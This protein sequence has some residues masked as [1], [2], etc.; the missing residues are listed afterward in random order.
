MVP[1]GYKVKLLTVLSIFEQ[2][3]DKEHPLSAD[4]IAEL[5]TTKLRI[6]CSRKGIYDDINALND[7]WDAVNDSRCIERDE[8]GKGYYLANRSFSAGDVKLMVDAIESSKYLSEAKTMKLITSLQKLCPETQVSDMK[9]QLVVFDRVKNMNTEI[10]ESLGTISFAISHD[11]QIR[12]KY[13]DY[14]MNKRRAY[15]KKGEFYQMSPYELIYT[16]DNY[17]LIAYDSIKKRRS[18]FRVDRMASITIVQQE[19]DGQEVFGDNKNEKL[20]IQKSTFSM[21]DGKI[22]TVTMRFRINMMNAVIDKFGSDVFITR[23][24][25]DH[26]QISV[27]VAISQQFYGWVFGLGNYVTITG[28]EY[29]K[30]EMAKK[31]EDI[32]KRY[33]D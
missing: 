10:H 25:K 3:T 1:D 2:K 27:P 23:I 7:Y 28:P 11:H 17:Y 5:V 30:K 31:L 15:R 33:N 16:D 26:F 14:D 6:P 13:F 32:R 12:F 8:K 19:R 9:S 4:K 29:I 21:F 22:E 24:D 20:R 18:T